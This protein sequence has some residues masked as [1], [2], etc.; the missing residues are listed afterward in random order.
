MSIDRPDTDPI[1]NFMASPSTYMEGNIA[2]KLK[3]IRK[4]AMKA[5]ANDRKKII[6][7]GNIRKETA[8]LPDGTVY[9]LTDTWTMAPSSSRPTST[10]SQTEVFFD[11]A[12]E[13]ILVDVDNSER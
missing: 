4:R 5:D 2:D 13:E 10:E 8:I 9:I 3:D 1:V 11:G 7:E 6:S 12:S